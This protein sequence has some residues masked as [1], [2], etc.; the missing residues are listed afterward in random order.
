[1]KRTILVILA[2]LLCISANAEKIGDCIQMNINS[3]TGLYSKGDTVVITATVNK[4]PDYPVILYKYENGYYKKPVSKEAIEL[5]E[6]ENILLKATYDKPTSILY[7]LNPE[8]DVK[9]RVYAGFLVDVDDLKCNITEPAD[10]MEFWNKEIAKMRAM[11]MQVEE[12]ELKAPKGFEGKVRVYD[13]TINCVGNR[14]AVA[15]VAEPLGAKNK[16][17]PIVIY[18]H[19]ASMGKNCRATAKKAAELSQFR[20]HDF[21]AADVNAHGID[22]HGSDQ[23]YKYLFAGELK[24]YHKGPLT[25]KEE[26]YFKNMFLRDLRVLDYLMQNPLW[27]GKTIIVNGGSQGGAQSAWVASVEPRVTGLVV[28]CPAMWAITLPGTEFN[29]S[30]PAPFKGQ[31]AEFEQI[32]P[33]YDMANLLKHTH[34][35]CWVEAGLWD[36]TVPAANVIAAFH[37]IP[38]KKELVTYKRTHTTVTTGPERVKLNDGIKK[39][40]DQILLDAQGPVETKF[41]SCKGVKAADVPALMKKKKVEYIPVK[42]ANWAK[43]P[44]CPDTK[45][46]IAACKEGLLLHYV[47]DEEAV[48]AT[49]AQDGEYVFEDASV[50]FFCKF[51][52]EETYYN[53]EFNCIG[54]ALVAAGEGRRGRTWAT[55]QVYGSIDRW[56]SLGKEPFDLKK[57]PTHWELALVIPYEA[58]FQSDVKALKGGSLKANFHKCGSK[59]PKKQFVTAFPVLTEKAELHSP[60]Y[61]REIHFSLR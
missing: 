22:N 21:L 57:T 1:M 2:V 10:L 25:T 19:G 39:F 47:V 6:G 34:A 61:F 17:L 18:Y 43:Y 23:Y 56:A 40:V 48:K 44:Y 42:C 50:E 8:S 36:S 59:L 13:A 16:S 41:L 58:F 30:W 4:I 35:A 15:I 9:D 24:N 45:V 7:A 27:D 28:H 3:T 14:P 29:T 60:Q 26:Y 31:D 51:P 20:G 53:F 54:K 11:K 49:H 52:G 46:A 55:E 5:K 32:M 33:Y 37:N 38:T 12:K